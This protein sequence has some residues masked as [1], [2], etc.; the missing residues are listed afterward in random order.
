MF[1]I[2][3]VY[4]RFLYTNFLIVFLF[5]IH[6]HYKQTLFVIFLLPNKIFNQVL[7]EH[8]IY[9]HPTEL[10]TALLNLNVFFIIVLTTPYVVWTII[11]FLGPGLFIE[12]YNKLIKFATITCV[13]ILALNIALFCMVFPFI[14]KFFQSFNSF[15][16]QSVIIKFELKIFEFIDFV[17]NIFWIIN[18]S[19]LLIFTLL[20]IVNTRGIAFYVKYKKFFVFLNIVAATLLS[21]PDIN[22]QLFLFTVLNIL[23]EIFQIFSS[24]STKI[25]KVAY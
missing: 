8:F 21:T 24:F 7:I 13:I 6:Y 10:L 19:L 3:E 20:L 18:V 22:S 15:E 23:L 14:L 16:L 17:Y 9:T 2:K 12:E 25:S 1:Y 5:F 11:D 4:F